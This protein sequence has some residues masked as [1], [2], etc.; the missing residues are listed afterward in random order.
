MVKWFMLPS[1][2]GGEPLIIGQNTIHEIYF[3]LGG[4]R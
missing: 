3:L 4:V 2:V 1:T